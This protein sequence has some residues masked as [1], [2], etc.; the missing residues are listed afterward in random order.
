MIV[1]R[2]MGE[3]YMKKIAAIL[4]SLYFLSSTTVAN[5]ADD[6][7]KL[8]T[9]AT[10]IFPTS[11]KLKNTGCQT[12]AI[13]I[14]GKSRI[15]HA[16]ALILDSEGTTVGGA[17]F[18]AKNGV[19]LRSTRVLNAKVCRHYWTFGARDAWEVEKGDYWMTISVINAD[20]RSAEEDVRIKFK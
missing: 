5:A 20:N 18:Y 12:F 4:V 11:V 10:A 14:K 1:M 7:I 13:S 6:S 15:Y 17:Y 8:G 16:E 3:R 2:R 19:Q 9:I